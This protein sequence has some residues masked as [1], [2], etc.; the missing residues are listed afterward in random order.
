[1]IQTHPELA[2]WLARQE[3]D[4]Q[5]WAE[6]TGTPETWDFSPASLDTLEAVVRERYADTRAINDARDSTFIQVASWYVGEIARRVNGAAWLRPPQCSPSTHSAPSSSN[7][8][9]TTT[10]RWRP[11]WADRC[12]M[13]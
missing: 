12:A 4:F 10:R 5:A 3:A 2:A 7:R 9:R 13:R 1:M 8:T 6:A 11:S